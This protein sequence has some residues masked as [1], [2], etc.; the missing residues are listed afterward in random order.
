MSIANSAFYRRLLF[1]AVTSIA[2]AITSS[3]NATADRMT[4]PFGLTIADEP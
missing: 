4:V 2:A 3:L 1:E